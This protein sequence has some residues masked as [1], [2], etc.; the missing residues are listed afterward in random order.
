MSS[1]LGQKTKRIGPKIGGKSRKKWYD[2]CGGVNSEV[3][4]SRG[5]MPTSTCSSSAPWSSTSEPDSFGDEEHDV[6]NWLVMVLAQ[7]ERCLR[8]GE[9]CKVAFRNKKN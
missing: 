9:L 5:G 4:S 2:R 3:L 1:W 8:D 6:W 7:L